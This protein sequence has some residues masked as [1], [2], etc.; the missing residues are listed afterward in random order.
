[1]H[2]GRKSIR[3]RFAAAGFSK[4]DQVAALQD[5]RPGLRLDGGRF[6]KAELS[7][8]GCHFICMLFGSS[9]AEWQH[10]VAPANIQTLLQSFVAERIHQT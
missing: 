7:E 6:V 10:T 4:T 2:S 1:V 9:K 8:L 3:V 5:D